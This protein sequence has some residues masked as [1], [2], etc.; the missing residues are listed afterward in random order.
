[1]TGAEF[2]AVVARLGFASSGK[3]NDEGL[4]AAARFF[5]ADP[6]SARRWLHSGPP[7]PVAIALRLMLAGKWDA[8]QA[9]AI[10]RARRRR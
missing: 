5:G 6:R 9:K 3:A 10:I 8:A 1:M 7:R 4:S 2:R